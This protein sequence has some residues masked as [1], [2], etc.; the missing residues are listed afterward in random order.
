MTQA[1][2]L[3]PGAQSD[4]VMSPSQ[5]AAYVGGVGA[6]KTFAGI[7]RGL[8]FSFQP[9]PQGVF[10]AARG[11]I[12]ASSYPVLRDVIVPSLEEIVNITGVANWAKDFK[13]SEKELTLING[14]VIRLRSLDKPDWQR[15]PEYAWFFIDEGR[16]VTMKAWEVLTGR[17]RQ[18]GY[19]TSGFVCSTPNGFDWMWRVFHEDSESRVKGAV[20]FNA[21]TTENKKLPPGYIDAL[22]ANYHG[23]FFEQEV[24]GKFVGLVEGGVFPYW[25]P[26]EHCL[27]LEYREDLPLYTGW[28]FGYGDMG[29]CVFMQVEWVDRVEA[30]GS[31]YMG[32]R[33]QVPYLYILDVIAEKEW[34]AADWALAYKERLQTRFK[35]RHS[36]G[37]YGDPAGMQRNPSTGTS[38]IT[39][40]NTAGVPVGPVL[41]RPQ[42]YSLRILNNM[43]AGSRVLVSKGASDLSHAFASHKWKLGPEGDKSAKDPV[44]DWTSHY[45]DAVR[46]PASVL[47][48][49]GP[50]RVEDQPEKEYAPNQY[51]HVFGQQLGEGPEERWIGGRKRRR[52]T[53]EPGVITPR[54]A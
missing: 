16:N 39:D 23:R 32:P 10:H 11:V 17:L 9:K 6:G 27:P 2:D 52:A 25:N 21:P 15:G 44:H 53:F 24:L 29:V 1:L 41:K 43:M 54:G 38:V 37:D 31:N 26:V 19:D 33:V 7:A 20:W 50:R 46:Y 40:L 36:D 45:V 48:P 51:G 8:R 42:D 22:T 30:D 49:F 35:G 28:D 5:Y 18:R 4:F 47:L 14:S 13:K 12:A 34:T 3:N